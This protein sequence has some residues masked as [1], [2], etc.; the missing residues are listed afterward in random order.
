MAKLLYEALE[1]GI[2]RRYVNQLLANFAIPA[3]QEA[4][5]AAAQTPKEELIEPL[6]DRELEVLQL[7]AGGLTNQEVASRL[8]LSLNTV[9]VHARNIFG[10][11]GVNNRTHAV[12]TGIRLGLVPSDLVLPES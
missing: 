10:K 7:I 8:F 9:K 4:P 1:Q 11:L 12:V 5:P 2:A 6:T 3:L